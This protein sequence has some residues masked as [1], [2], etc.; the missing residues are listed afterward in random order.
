MLKL[1]TIHW[2]NQAGN[3][4]ENEIEEEDVEQ[5]ERTKKLQR[6]T[7]KD[8]KANI[9]KYWKK[10]AKGVIRKVKTTKFYREWEGV[11]GEIV[12]ED[13]ITKEVFDECFEG[14]GK[15]IQ[16]T[17]ENKP[18]S[19]LFIIIFD[20]WEKIEE[21]FGKGKIERDDYDGWV[22]Q[23]GGL[24]T[25]ARGFTKSCQLFQTKVSL[26]SLEVNYNKSRMKLEL[27]FRAIGENLN[28]DL[29][30]NTNQFFAS[31][32]PNDSIGGVL[33]NSPNSPYNNSKTWEFKS[34]D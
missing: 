13:T 3:D 7:E 16:P 24:P 20:C 8:K 1:N 34:I 17:P 26:S 29:N 31:T 32:N 27:K 2:K 21:L 30:T 15:L 18:T 5:D 28:N 25:N 33:S 4:P 14:R 9:K 23:R 11:I 12:V 22:W 6:I 19:V 10:W